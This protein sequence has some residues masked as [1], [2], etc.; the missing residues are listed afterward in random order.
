MSN[1]C[2]HT[3]QLCESETIAKTDDTYETG[4][5]CDECK[6]EY[7]ANPLLYQCSRCGFDLCQKCAMVSTFPHT[8]N[9]L[10]FDE[11]KNIRLKALIEMGVGRAITKR[12]YLDI[13]DYCASTHY[14]LRRKLPRKDDVIFGQQKIKSYVF[15]IN[16][17]DIVLDGIKF[18]KKKINS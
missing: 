17:V 11:D 8:D 16:D 6:C 2:E 1:Q 10:Y 12:Q 13:A 14:Y 3:F 7:G 18:Y 4:F 15:T 5:I 9:H